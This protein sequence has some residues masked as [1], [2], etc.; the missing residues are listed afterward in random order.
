LILV[1]NALVVEKR[2]HQQDGAAQQVKLPTIDSQ[3]R[4]RGY[5]FIAT[6]R[7]STHLRGLIPSDI[8]GDE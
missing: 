1:G 2:Q 8:L 4:I 3:H 5:A 6:Q 7:Y